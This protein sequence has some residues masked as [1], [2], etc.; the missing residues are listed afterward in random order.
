MADRISKNG[1]AQ[2]DRRSNAGTPRWVK[3]F[4]IIAL[5][6]LVLLVI[7][8]LAGLSPMSHTHGS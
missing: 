4:G 7:M 2:P 5:A 8:H 1:G 3:V 6:L